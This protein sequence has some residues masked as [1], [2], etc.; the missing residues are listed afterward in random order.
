MFPGP[1][2][3]YSKRMTSGDYYDREEPLFNADL[4]LKDINHA[5]SLA[6]A[7]GTRMKS[8]ELHKAHLEQVQKSAAEQGLPADLAGIY[9]VVR[10][11]SGL[12][13]KNK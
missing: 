12:P 10:E 5:L 2:P 7:S 13:F 4:A 1:Y 9:G 3:P 6:K 8:A 11:E